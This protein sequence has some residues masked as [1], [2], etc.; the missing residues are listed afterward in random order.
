[1]MGEV[2]LV[3]VSEGLAVMTDAE[4]AGRVGA[5]EPGGKL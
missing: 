1:M 2:H 5:P 4:E 3:L